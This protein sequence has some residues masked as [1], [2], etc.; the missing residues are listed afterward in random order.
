MRADVKL[1]VVVSAVLV[2][3]VG[4]YF[5]FR[6]DGSAPATKG[7][8]G[9]TVATDS[10]APADAK[11]GRLSGA[12]S[13]P[14]GKRVFAKVPTGA[15]GKP[16]AAGPDPSSPTRR[17][18][19]AP[20]TPA[21]GQPATSS[22]ASTTGH[23]SSASP[24]PTNPSANP[25]TGTARLP[26][27]AP[28]VTGGTT[29]Q[30][31]GKDAGA[32]VTKEGEVAAN[33]PVGGPAAPAPISNP[34]SD[35]S[36]PRTG[37]PSSAAIP[38]KPEAPSEGAV[39][40]ASGVNDS[41]PPASG[42]SVPVPS[43]RSLSSVTSPA[44]SSGAS[45]VGAHDAGAGTSS[46]VVGD[47]VGIAVD[48]HR[49]QPGDTL[50]ALAKTY[51]GNERYARFLKESNP[52]SASAEPLTPGTVIRI[53]ANPTDTAPDRS[54]AR[55]GAA[56]LASPVTAP[57]SRADSSGKSAGKTYQVRTGDSFY[58]IARTVLG[59][60]KRWKDLYELNRKAVRD[61]P[62]NLRPGQVLTLPER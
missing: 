50:A 36:Q 2:S 18:A 25:R 15:D 40:G 44:G 8:S 52:Q 56:P 29:S 3:V 54:A 26:L 58:S 13:Q 45:P 55:V 61:D 21:A 37:S 35:G 27:T 39:S 17:R 57:T 1:G 48:T 42:A 59:D 12:P 34:G 53:P 62:K 7:A 60:S 23:P 5:T 32:A 4:G 9:A 38:S 11:D 31:T 46:R 41:A 22:P 6:G 33:R 47:R 28:A 20:V 43:P 16:L 51:Y 14:S 10:K 19:T 24:P 49:V 30:E